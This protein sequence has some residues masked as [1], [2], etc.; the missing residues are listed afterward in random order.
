MVIVEWRRVGG[1]GRVY[2][3]ISN[4]GN[5]FFKKFKKSTTKKQRKEMTTYARIVI[6][7]IFPA[8]P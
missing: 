1:S 3:G 8:C 4:D 7:F 6:S 2:G 5:N